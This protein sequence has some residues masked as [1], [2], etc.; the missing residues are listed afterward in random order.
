MGDFL[1]PRPRAKD[2]SITIPS[3][4]W[5][6]VIAFFRSIPWAGQMAWLAEA[7]ASS[8]HGAQLYPVT[9]MHTIVIG[10]TPEF[11]LNQ[12]VLRIEPT[13]D[14]DVIDGVRFEYVEA[15]WV[16]VKWRRECRIEEAPGVLERFLARA[17]W[18]VEYR[19]AE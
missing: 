13:F 14:R 9:S 4:P 16:P 5:A 1:K 17:H 3:R 12:G 18:F 19:P 2:G 10:Q 7:I 6:S 11:S 15:P 8:R